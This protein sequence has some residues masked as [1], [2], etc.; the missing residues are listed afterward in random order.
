MHIESRNKSK[1][2]SQV[3]MYASLVE[4][5]CLENHLNKYVSFAL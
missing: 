2:N 1:L 3:G 5:Q 4:E